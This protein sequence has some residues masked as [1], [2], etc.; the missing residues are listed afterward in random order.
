ME[1]VESLE[2]FEKSANIMLWYIS[3]L[4]GKM[5]KNKNLEKKLVVSKNEKRNSE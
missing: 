1:S 4:V 5:Q 3:Q 2:D